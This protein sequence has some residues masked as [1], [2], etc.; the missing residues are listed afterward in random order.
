MTFVERCPVQI[1][2]VPINYDTGG[3]AGVLT[4]D[5]ARMA[6]TVTNVFR[7]VYPIGSTGQL[8]Y[9]QILPAVTYAG[10]LDTA[11]DR[12]R[13]KV[14]LRTLLA[15]AQWPQQLRKPLSQLVGWLPDMPQV[16]TVRGQADPSWNDP[17][18]SDQVFWNQTY[19]RG[20]WVLAHEIGHNFG[21]HHPNVADSGTASDLRSRWPLFYT[22][23]LI[24]EV[25]CDAFDVRF[26]DP[27]KRYDLMTY[28]SSLWISPL[29]YSGDPFGERG[30]YQELAPPCV[31][32]AAVGTTDTTDEPGTA[33]LE[34]NASTLL[35][36]S[37]LLNAD[38]S[39]Q[40]NP[41]TRVSLTQAPALPKAGSTFCVALLASGG[42][43]LASYCF[44]L[45][46][47]DYET[48]EALASSP[49]VMFVPD[50]TGVTEVVL[51]RE[52]S[53]VARRVRSS[54]TPQVTV[55]E[56]AGG[57][58]WTGASRI[59]WTA[60]DADGDPL[61]FTVLFSAN[62]KGSWRGLDVDI[63]GNELVVDANALPGT[64]QGY[65]RVLAT[66][67]LNT[68]QGDSRAAIRVAD[69]APQV[70]ITHPAD[71]V[72]WTPGTALILQGSAYDRE[73]GFLGGASLTWR[74]DR[75]GVLGT[76][77]TVSLT[78]LAPVD[79]VITL[80]ARDAG[81]REGSA[82]IVVRVPRRT[83]LPLIMHR[84]GSG[85]AIPT[86]T[87]TPAV[88][89]TVLFR[90]SFSTAGLPGWTATGGTWTNPGGVMRGASGPGTDAWNI[91]GLP[92]FNFTYEGTVTVRNGSVAGLAFRSTDGTQG[93]DL[94]VDVNG[95]QLVL[96]RRPYTAL[97]SYAVDIRRDRP[98]RL[99][100]EARGAAIDA[101]LDG[102]K[103][104]SVVDAAYSRGNFGVSA[105]NSVADY[106]DLIACALDVPYELRVDAGS[107]T[108]TVD[109]AGRTWLAGR[110]YA[111]GSWGFTD[112]VTAATTDPIASTADD[113]LYQTVHWGYGTWSFKADVPNGAYRVN[114]GF[115]ETYFT[116]ANI[117]VF[118][119]KIEGQTMITGLDLF[120][121]A[122]HDTA[123]R[124]S[125][126]VTVNDGRLDIEFVSVK[127]AALVAAIEVLG[128]GSAAPTPTRTPT[129]TRTPARCRDSLVIRR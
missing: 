83:Y 121:A 60:S 91:V 124:R 45:S 31:P 87:P 41:I 128:A 106:D 17:L 77:A 56:P 82:S 52:G 18:G 67:G 122:G 89:C 113:L 71:G 24:Q 96:A 57:E 78:A 66:D 104:I 43:E 65:I 29:H 63:A 28:R 123:Y 6:L 20:D 55:V 98:Y 44:D 16:T 92:S 88:P 40:L 22:S 27:T 36:I 129:I 11:E 8:Q 75:A 125:F 32:P 85:P 58:L 34:G 12:H 9:F 61:R 84:A 2:Y 39:G 1:G 73:E 33:P 21:L 101:Y 70:S 79:Q 23:S 111:A 48:Q 115:A 37:G 102:V 25:G 4:P 7:K 30:L 26:Y 117:R 80:T 74:S 116:A 127:N 62:G 14:Y 99:R 19:A 114:L 42:A 35:M 119:V 110:F 94:F 54:N 59:R 15:L 120:A 53:I 50:R 103:R 93:Y 69:K 126:D 76:G 118:N 51:R 108:D 72:V 3:P 10:S 90:D 107:G 64:S 112:G 86:P 38:G 81:G 100:V 109:A 68:G 13:L 46:F 5:P 95:G 49:F 105:Y 97:G 47:V